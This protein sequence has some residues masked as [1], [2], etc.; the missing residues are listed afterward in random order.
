MVQAEIIEL[1]FLM[2][3][4][5]QC[6]RSKWIVG[7]LIQTLGIIHEPVK[8]L[9]PDIFSNRGLWLQFVVFSLKSVSSLSMIVSAQECVLTIA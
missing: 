6:A 5:Q 8:T 4:D 9:F 2:Q 1:C 7:D 3:T